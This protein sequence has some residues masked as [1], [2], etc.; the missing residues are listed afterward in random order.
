[1]A[2]PSLPR[3]SRH[4]FHGTPEWKLSGIPSATILRSSCLGQFQLSFSGCRAGTPPLRRTSAVALPRLPKERSGLAR[5]S[6]THTS[7]AVPRGRL[8]PPSHGTPPVRMVMTREVEEIGA[9][10]LFPCS[11]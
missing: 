2:G 7:T 4:P 1:M 6:A 10:V 5:S 11:A 3:L 8:T 9:R